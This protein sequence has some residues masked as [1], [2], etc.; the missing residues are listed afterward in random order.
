MGETKGSGM[1]GVEKGEEKERSENREKVWRE[2]EV[3]FLK[4]WYK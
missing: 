2:R 1:I 3:R 4:R